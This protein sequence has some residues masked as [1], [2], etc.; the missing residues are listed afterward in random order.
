MNHEEFEACFEEQVSQSREVLI[1]K[2]KEYASDEDRLH[3]FNR[4]AS[5]MGG[6]PEK[7]CWGFMVKHLTSLSDMVESGK[8]Y[9]MAVWDEKL[10]DAMN[11]LFLLKAIVVDREMNQ[12]VSHPATIINNHIRYDKTP[13]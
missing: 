10:G 8:D 4:S 3:N 5:L 7:A 1:N 2:A 13:Q 11:Y 9:P 12:Y 6:R